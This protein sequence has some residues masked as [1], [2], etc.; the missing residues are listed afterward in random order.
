MTNDVIQSIHQRKHTIESPTTELLLA[1]QSVTQAGCHILAATQALV[2][3][4]LQA[5]THTS[6]TRYDTIPPPGTGHP[7]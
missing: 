6:P 3:L 5:S 4:S 1:L 2:I 7:I